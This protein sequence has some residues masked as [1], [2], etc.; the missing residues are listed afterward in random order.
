[1]SENDDLPE[2]EEVFLSADNTI[3]YSTNLK[4]SNKLVKHLIKDIDEIQK[5][6]S[7]E[8]K[9]NAELQ[10]KLELHYQTIHCNIS[11]FTFRNYVKTA[12]G[13]NETESEW[14]HFIHSFNHGEEALSKRINYWIDYHI[15]KK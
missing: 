12:V 7:E 11:R 1:M 13:R 14:I 3:G 15:L 9:K 4:E 2:K 6:L 5:R 8:I 10:A